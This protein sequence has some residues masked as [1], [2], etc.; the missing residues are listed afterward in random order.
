MLT[1]RQGANVVMT[2]GEAQT[3]GLQHYKADPAKLNATVAGMNDVQNKLNQLAAVTTDPSRM[4]QV[5]PAGCRC[6]A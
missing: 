3:Q 2:K 1:A 6:Y 5:R 4:S